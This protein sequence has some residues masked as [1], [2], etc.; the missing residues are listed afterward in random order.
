MAESSLF[1][2]SV[3]VKRPR[4][5]ISGRQFRLQLPPESTP[6]SGQRLIK[7]ALREKLESM[8]PA[9]LEHYSSILKIPVPDFQIRELGNRW[10]SCS[11]SGSLRFHWLLAT[12]EPQF[13]SHVIAHELCHLIEPQHSAEFRRLL[14]KICPR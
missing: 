5:E 10:G 12:Q 9:L 11:Q 6:A 14:R 7:K 4:L 8:L 2:I 3:D 1:G 13:V